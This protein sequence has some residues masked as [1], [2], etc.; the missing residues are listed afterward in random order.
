MNETWAVVPGAA[1]GLYLVTTHNAEPIVWDW[2]P[3]QRE[4]EPGRAWSTAHAEKLLH[5]L[6]YRRT[7]TWATREWLD[8]GVAAPVELN[9]VKEAA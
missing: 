6:G 1:V 3:A 2:I 7:D 5:H 4:L 9:P 8:T